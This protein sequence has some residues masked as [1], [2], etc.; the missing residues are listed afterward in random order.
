MGLLRYLSKPFTEMPNNN[1]HNWNNLQEYTRQDGHQSHNQKKE[2]RTP[3][4]YFLTKVDIKETHKP[5]SSFLTKAEI[6]ESVGL[7]Y[8]ICIAIA[9]NC[10]ALGTMVCR[11]KETI[12]GTQREYY[13]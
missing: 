1:R 8:N 11:T 13:I 2:T 6:K 12:I 7:I 4:S 5:K 10:R 3:S 9:D